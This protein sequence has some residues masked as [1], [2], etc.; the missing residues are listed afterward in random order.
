MNIDDHQRDHVQFVKEAF[1]YEGEERS[2]F[3]AYLANFYKLLRA[4]YKFERV[5]S[6]PQ[7]HR[8]K[9]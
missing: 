2:S 3:M 9:E 7:I 4:Q 5:S 1:L 6:S 8:S